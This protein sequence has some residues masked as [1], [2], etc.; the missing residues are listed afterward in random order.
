MSVDP[1]VLCADSC[2]RPAVTERL[3]GMVGDSELVDLVCQDCAD[4]H[5]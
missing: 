3:W 2:G 5:P 4:A 1:D